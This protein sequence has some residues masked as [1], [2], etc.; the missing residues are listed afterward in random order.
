MHGT[1]SELGGTVVR[2]GVD[3]LHTKLLLDEIAQS[4]ELP[5]R[6]LQPNFYGCGSCLSRLR[7]GSRG[8]IYN[9]GNSS[10]VWLLHTDTTAEI[11]LVCRQIN[12]PS[13]KVSGH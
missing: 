9:S 13:C 1:A 11:E 8:T 7:P 10:C 2:Q 12:L 5:A 6:T 4:A 3:S